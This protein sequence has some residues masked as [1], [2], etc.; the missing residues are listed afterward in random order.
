MICKH[1]QNTISSWD[2]VPNH[3]CFINKNVY[4]DDDNVLFTLESCPE[5]NQY[6]IWNKQST[7]ALLSSYEMNLN[8]ADNAKKK[9]KIWTAITEGLQELGIKVTNDQVRWKINSLIKKYKECVDNN[10]KS[11]RAHMSFEF[12]DQLEEILGQEK[13]ATAL[14]TVSSKILLDSDSNDKRENV[15]E[16]LSNHQKRQKKADENNRPNTSTI[17]HESQPVVKRLRPG[18]GTGSTL[19]KT[20]MEL[21][22]QWLDYLKTT[23][24][25]EEEQTKRHEK[26]LQSKVEVINV[27]KRQLQLKK[28]IAE[29]KLKSKERRHE[30]IIEL[31]KLKINLLKKLLRSGEK[32]RNQEDSDSD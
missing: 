21:Q 13:E 9:T 19:A 28:E 7:L 12:Y 3:K 24:N 5:N 6:A 25:R 10:A 18:H 23:K 15:D 20:K 11:G 17:E 8:K 22:T 4:M 29:K 30:D 2:A 31:E 32:V 1:Y 14:H 16:S 27:K 26:L